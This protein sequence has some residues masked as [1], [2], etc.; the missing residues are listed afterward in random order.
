M[1]SVNEYDAVLALVAAAGF[2]IERLVEPLP[3]D[4]MRERWPE[5]YEKLSREPGFLALRLLRS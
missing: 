1:R 3:A 4:S 5:A 2:L